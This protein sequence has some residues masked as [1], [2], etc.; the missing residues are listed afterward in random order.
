MP[1]FETLAVAAVVF[2]AGLVGGVSGFGFA[3]VVVPILSV[4]IGPTEAVLLVNAVSPVHSLAMFLLLRRDV[5][6]RTAIRLLIAGAF[7]MPLGAYALVVMSADALRIA[8]GATV[9]A[10]TFVLW[11][12]FQVHRGGAIAE[13][14]TGFVSGVLKTSTGING[15]PLVLYLQ[16]TGIEA[17]PFR[18]TTSAV[19]LV[20]GVMGAVVLAIGNQLTTGILAQSA[21]AV[22]FIFAGLLTGNRLF[23]GIAPARFRQLVL[24]LLVASSTVIIATTLLR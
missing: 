11:R 20:S 6:W 18:A 2:L 7:G 8:I 15:P 21:I 12:G 1:V 14:L 19:F 10:G 4:V 5:R 17:V 23:T 24:G 16:G 9:L 22:P 3:L 13:A